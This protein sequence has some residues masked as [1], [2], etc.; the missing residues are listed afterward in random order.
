MRVFFEPTADS[1]LTIEILLFRYPDNNVIF[2]TLFGIFDHIW[3][4]RIGCFLVDRCH[5][6]FQILTINIPFFGKFFFEWILSNVK[7]LRSIIH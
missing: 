1:N 4:S 2:L 3:R 7:V 5:R 6:T